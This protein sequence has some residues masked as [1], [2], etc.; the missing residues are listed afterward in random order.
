MIVKEEQ[1]V[2]VPRVTTNKVRVLRM[3][4]RNRIIIVII[5]V[6][7]VF[8][9]VIVVVVIIIIIIKCNIVAELATAG[10]DRNL[11]CCKGLFGKLNKVYISAAF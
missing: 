11:A 9:V 5:V 1:V 2:V 3:S 10:R 7:V 8:V 6:V 4:N